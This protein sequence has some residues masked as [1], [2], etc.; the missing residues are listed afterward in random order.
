MR[1]WAS[2]HTGVYTSCPEA[3]LAG[4]LVYVCMEQ[5]LYQC[6]LFILHLFGTRL[7]YLTMDELYFENSDVNLVD[8]E[9]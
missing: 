7:E 2:L 8:V 9:I 3:V 4:L 5:L 6:I 1:N